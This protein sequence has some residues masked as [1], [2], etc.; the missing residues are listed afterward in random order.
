MMAKEVEVELLQDGSTLHI[1]VADS[2]DGVAP[3]FVE[4]VFTEGTSTKPESGH[5]RRT[6]DRHGVVPPDQPGPR[7][8]RT[9]VERRVIP[10]PSCVARSSSPGCR[11]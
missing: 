11:V 10:M 9:T 8:R 5:T 3:E 6:R 2:G 4:H 1:T 7:R